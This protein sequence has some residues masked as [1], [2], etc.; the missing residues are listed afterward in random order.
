MKSNKKKGLSLFIGS[1]DLDADCL[2]HVPSQADI[3]L[4]LTENE[5]GSGLQ[6]GSISWLVSGMVIED[7]QYIL[8]GVKTFEC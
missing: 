5:N 6:S 2:M 8:S 4:K 1:H 3:R 7:A